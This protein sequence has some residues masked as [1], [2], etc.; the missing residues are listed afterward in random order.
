MSPLPARTSRE[1]A[2]LGGGE[3]GE[4]ATC[5]ARADLL[6]LL[7]RCFLQSKKSPY[8]STIVKIYTEEGLG[9][10]YAGLSSSVSLIHRLCL[11]S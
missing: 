10:L 9:G 5:L 8:D 11:G 1:S 6:S 4:R 3:A 7:L 2:K